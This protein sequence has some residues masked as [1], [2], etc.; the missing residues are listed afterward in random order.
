MDRDDL[1]LPECEPV[2]AQV[3]DLIR[4]LYRKR[5]YPTS[6][7][8]SLPGDAI[9]TVPAGR[10]RMRRALRRLLGK[11]SAPPVG[12]GERGADYEPLPGAADDNRL[13]WFLYWEIVWALTRGP[14]LKPGSRILDA[15]GTS[16][17][18]TC[19]LATLGH[20][21]HSVDLNEL[22]VANGQAISAGMKWNNMQSYCMNMANLT[23]EDAFFDHAS[24]ICVFEHLT[25]DLKQAALNEIARVLKPGGIL[26]ITFDYQNPAPWIVGKGPD[27]SFE[28]QIS[29]EKDIQRSFLK[30]GCFELVG[31]GFRD[32]GKR[33][34]QHFTDTQKRYT[35][36]A[37][38][39]RVMK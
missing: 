34:L 10:G 18:F 9:E 27:T 23:F 35:F 19:Y 16:S 38:F 39:L 33:W 17:L 8:G 20:E 29:S 1:F 14:K 5:L 28:N 30:T 32:C 3:N 4:K 37:L 7:Y 15:G 22:L 2:I 12:L 24:S 6:W 26:S 11:H 21:L 13:P 31:G 25:Y 36:G